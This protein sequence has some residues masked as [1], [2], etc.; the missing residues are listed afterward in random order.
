M[1]FDA[2]L[3]DCRELDQALGW[4]VTVSDAHTGRSGRNTWTNLLRQSPDLRVDHAVLSRQDCRYGRSGLLIA[5]EA[6]NQAKAAPAL[7]GMWV[8]STSL[9]VNQLRGSRLWR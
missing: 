5:S 6:N 1:V 2:G 3:P 9:S 4:T 8:V 7:W